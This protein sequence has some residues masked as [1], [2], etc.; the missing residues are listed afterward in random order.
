MN[1]KLAQVSGGQ[2]VPATNGTITQKPALNSQQQPITLMQ[3]CTELIKKLLK[4][5]ITKLN[6][7]L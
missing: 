6:T 3:V 2:A 5:L 1:L 7:Y 4:D